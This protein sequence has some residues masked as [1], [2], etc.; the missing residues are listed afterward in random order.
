M[1]SEWKVTKNQGQKIAVTLRWT[2]KK[3]QNRKK[4]SLEKARASY[5]NI[6]RVR[7]AWNI[8]CLLHFLENFYLSLRTQ[9]L[10][11][12]SGNLSYP[13][14]TPSVQ[15]PVDDGQLFLLQDSIVVFYFI[16]PTMLPHRQYLIRL[17]Q[18]STCLFS[19]KRQ[20]V[21]DQALCHSQAFPRP[22]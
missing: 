12:S 18:E 21:C 3:L 10:C 16:Y 14:V 8:S 17:K 11:L 20:A 22:L 19:P 15:I 1:V 4:N 6:R 5:Q 13:F 2:R 9:N 7:E